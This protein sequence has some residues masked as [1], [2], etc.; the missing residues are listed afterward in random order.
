MRLNSLCRSPHGKD[1]KAVTN[2]WHQLACHVSQLPHVMYFNELAHVITETVKS[3]ICRVGLSAG[4]QGRADAAFP[5]QRPAAGRVP[6]SWRRPVFCLF[7]PTTD[8]MRPTQILENNL[9]YSEST[10]LN[11]NLYQKHP[12]RNI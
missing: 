3:K 2:S 6:S 12:R 10:D 7:S 8:W 1:L 4:T 11:I 9:L 5:V